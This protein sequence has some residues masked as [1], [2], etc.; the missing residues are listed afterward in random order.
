MTTNYAAWAK[1]GLFALFLALA[2]VASLLV[3]RVTAQEAPATPVAPAQA[4][5]PDILGGREAEP[6]A[7]PWQV[8]LVSSFQDNAYLGQICGGTLIGAEWV[9]TAA[10]CVN[11]KE[12]SFIEALVGAHRLSDTGERVKV[13]QIIQHADYD[14]TQLD[15]DL[16]LLRLSAPV[17]YTPISLY[18]A[19][20]GATELDF[21]RATVIGWGAKSVTFDWFF[22]SFEY[23]DALREVSLPLVSQAQCRQNLYYEDI[24]DNMLCAGYETLSKGTCYG[25]SGGPLMVQKP[26]ASWAQ[27]GIVSWGPSECV[28]S[29]QYDVYTRVSRYYDWIT[30]CMA[31]PDATAC[32]GGDE[33]EPDNSPAEAQQ[34]AAPIVNQMHTF[35]EAGDQDW[36]RFDVEAGKEYLFVTGRITDTVAPLRTILWLFDANGYT[37]ITYTEGVNWWES[38]YGSGFTESARIVWK[39]DRT[40]PIYVSVELLPY[41]YGQDYG[42][43]TR[44]WL[45]IGAYAEH[46]LPAVQG[47]VETPTAAPT[48]AF[49]NPIVTPYPAS[50]PIGPLLPTP[51]D[52]F[53][54]PAAP[55]APGIPATPIP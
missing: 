22:I 36:V 25:D 51:I 33:Y 52:P 6:G 46:F 2:L 18:Q 48:D 1:M 21:M 53:P 13:A 42:V 41:L 39:A 35:H 20:T 50:T 40:G 10:H 34:L 9:L 7:W 27:I 54:T 15:N 12:P 43:Q 45:T 38:Y 49:G 19:I 47:P 11:N 8:A 24:T 30:T 14:P 5:A 44:Y 55:I 26:D 28:A 31:N 29:G 4:E 37:P 32:R 16:A 17:T 3:E 23:S